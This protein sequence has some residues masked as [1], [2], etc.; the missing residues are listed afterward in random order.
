MNRFRTSL[1]VLGAL[2]LFGFSALAL[3]SQQEKKEKQRPKDAPTLDDSKGTLTETT[4]GKENT[5]KLELKYSLKV[6]GYFDKDGFNIEEVEEGGPAAKLASSTGTEKYQLE[7]GDIITEVDGKAL[8][9]ADDYVKA[10]NEASDPMKLKIK[11]KDVKKGEERELT[12]E[13]AK[14][15]SA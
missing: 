11:V 2:M 15:E 12:A 3:A 13:A 14:R 9:S 5:K 7:K 8:K 4:D 10:I 1:L 6:K